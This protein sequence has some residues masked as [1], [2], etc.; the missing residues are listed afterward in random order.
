M[1]SLFDRRSV[2]L[3][4]LLDLSHLEPHV[5]S[6]LQRVYACLAVG[7]LSAAAGAY[8]G[9]YVLPMYGLM[10]ALV[11][12]GLIFYL[13]SSREDLSAQRHAVFAA[14]CAIAGS[15]LAPLINIAIDIDPSILVNAVIVTLVVTVC[16]SGAALLAKTS[17]W[18]LLLAAP[19]ASGLTLLMLLSL[20]N[21]FS[22][23]EFIFDMTLKLTLIIFSAFMVYDTQ[24][25]V[26][27]A[28]LGDK[29]YILHCL[30]LF[31]DVIEVF[32]VVLILLMKMQGNGERSERKKRKD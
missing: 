17:R 1:D 18:M 20:V 11:S 8:I 31:L 10:A 29:D 12:I 3:R 2:T 6:H 13:H 9:M 4:G 19:L 32:R 28:R 23:S 27:M 25:I 26:E 5:L 22:R 30:D 16:F 7:L 24:K 15:G 14:F 21:I